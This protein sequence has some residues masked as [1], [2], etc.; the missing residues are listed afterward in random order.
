MTSPLGK[1]LHVL[2]SD[3]SSDASINLTDRSTFIAFGV[4]VFRPILRPTKKAAEAAF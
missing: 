4:P 1:Q 2:D 3:A